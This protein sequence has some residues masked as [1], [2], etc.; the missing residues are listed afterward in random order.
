M[1]KKVLVTLLHGTFAPDAEWTK[2]GSMLRAKLQTKIE[3]VTFDPFP[4]SGANS[5][6]ERLNE[7]KKLGEHIKDLQI[8]HPDSEHYIIAHSHAGNI[9]LYAAR[10]LGSSH[11]LAGI[12]C[13]ATPFLHVKR[14][15]RG[16]RT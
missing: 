10:W 14:T 8:A 16:H 5:M 3:N 1:A 9:A 15:V 2:P 6:W 12:A 11:D 7:G 13:L 4:W